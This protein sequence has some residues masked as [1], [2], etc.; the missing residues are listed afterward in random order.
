ML[1]A[2]DPSHPCKNNTQLSPKNLDISATSLSGEKNVVLLL[3]N[4]G[5]AVYQ[6]SL[7]LDPFSNSTPVQETVLAL[8]RLSAL[9]ASV[10]KIV[11]IKESRGGHGQK[12]YSKVLAKVSTCGHKTARR[13]GYSVCEVLALKEFEIDTESESVEAR[14]NFFFSMSHSATQTL[15]LPCVS[16]SFLAIQADGLSTSV[17]KSLRDLHD[18]YVPEFADDFKSLHCLGSND[19]WL[20]LLRAIA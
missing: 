20:C 2:R 3:H 17:L 10:T 7:G 12:H 19:P 1:A 5:P 4:A 6:T 14:Q 18:C 15:T 8:A 13:L 9:L 11:V 16:K